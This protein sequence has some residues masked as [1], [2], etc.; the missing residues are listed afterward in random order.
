MAHYM[1]EG[2]IV[3]SYRQAKDRIK[4]IPILAQLNN[5]TNEEIIEI[6]KRNGI[7]EEELPKKRATKN[8]CENKKADDKRE[9]TSIAEES[10]DN[11][12]EKKKEYGVCCIPSAVKRACEE[13][14]QALL[15]E[16][17]ALEEEYDQLQDFL[18]EVKKYEQAN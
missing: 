6:L 16:I 12:E 4:Q 15:G 11:E 1:S 9:K 10:T 2:E 13:K 3:S 18:M 17:I 5:S 7:S 8:K 14:A